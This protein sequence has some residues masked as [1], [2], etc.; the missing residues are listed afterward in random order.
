MKNLSWETTKVNEEKTGMMDTV[1]LEDLIWSS[2]Q[3]IKGR[4]LL[5]GGGH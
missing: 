1:L 3:R 4:E 2:A 5:E